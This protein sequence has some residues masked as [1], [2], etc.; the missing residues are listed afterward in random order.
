MS[1]S[2]TTESELPEPRD[3]LYI[4]VSRIGDTLLVTPAVRAVAARWPRARSYDTTPPSPR[5]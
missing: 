3:I 4:N 2:A 5:S 1:S